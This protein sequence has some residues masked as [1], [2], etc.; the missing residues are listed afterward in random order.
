MNKVYAVIQITHFPFTFDE[1]SDYVLVGV[2]SEKN[3]AEEVSD[4]FKRSYVMEIDLNK[5]VNQE[6]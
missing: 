1:C 6:I 5:V 4:T 3:K 2:F